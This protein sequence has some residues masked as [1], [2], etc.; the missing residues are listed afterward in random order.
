MVLRKSLILTS[1]LLATLLFTSSQVLA[2]NINLNS[3]EWLGGMKLDAAQMKQIKSAVEKALKAP[4]DAEQ[5]CGKERL[6]CVVRAAREWNYKG[7]KYRE[8]V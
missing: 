1:M 2:S 8:I 4:I 3:G 5:Q 6:D 7:E